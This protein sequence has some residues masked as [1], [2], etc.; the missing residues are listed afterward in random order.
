MTIDSPQKR[1]ELAVKYTA[2]HNNEITTMEKD[3]V[4]VQLN[5][6]ENGTIKRRFAKEA[7]K[8]Y[9]HKFGECQTFERLHERGG[10]SVDE[11]CG[12]LCDRLDRLT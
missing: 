2:Q 4:P 6:V 8:E 3:R 5:R 11:L 7:Y 10:F 9:L 12:L 1:Y